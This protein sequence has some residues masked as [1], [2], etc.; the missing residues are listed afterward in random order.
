LIVFTLVFL[1]HPDKW[2]YTRN[3]VRYFAGPEIRLV[4][5][6]EGWNRYQ[7]AARLQAEGIL[8]AE[9]FLVLT[10]EPSILKELGIKAS[11]AEGYLF[12]DTYQFYAGGSP[13][14]ILKTMTENFQEK[15]A[16]LK[17]KYPGGLDRYKDI[18]K[19]PEHAAV[20]VASIVEEEVA[21]KSE[22]AIVADVFLKRLT[23]DSF[24]PHLLQADPT[25]AYGC[26]DQNPPPPSCEKFDG[27]LTRKHL[28]DP[29]NLYNTYIYV[30]LPPGPISNPGL[31]SLK[32]ALNPGKTTYYYFVSRGDG[33]HEFS[34]T[35]EE[36]KEAVDKYRK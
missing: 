13:L 19:D 30:G 32:A 9:D 15:F 28:K 3:L 22:A 27:V 36:H 5:V 16:K 31:S 34:A 11:T 14:T 33:T 6:P 12:P 25:V 20:I 1:L 17:K 21:R 24:E 10:E 7:I 8:R 23:Y 26:L 4:T 2:I 29:D 35:L 18:S